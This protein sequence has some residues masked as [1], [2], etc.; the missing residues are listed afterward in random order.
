ME[1]TAAK[2]VVVGCFQRA[3]ASDSSFIDRSQKHAPFVDGQLSESLPPS[4][5][6]GRL[7]LGGW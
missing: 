2:Q 1:K 5:V 7:G 6:V 4:H 3:A